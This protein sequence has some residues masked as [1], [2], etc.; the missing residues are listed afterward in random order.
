MDTRDILEQLSKRC[1]ERFESESLVLSFQEYLAE[2]L[3]RPRHHGRIA[4]RYIADCFEHFGTEVVDG[5]GGEAVRFKLFDAP[6]DDGREPLIGQE[7][8]QR[9]FYQAL[10]NFARDGRADR[11]I[12]LHGPN[13]SAKTTFCELVFRALEAYSETTEGCLHRFS[14]IFPNREAQGG[15]LGFSD[16][17][18]PRG[19]DQTY[20]FLG[21]DEIAAKIACEL[22]DPP[23]YL[24]PSDLRRELFEDLF[25]DEADRRQHAHLIEGEL[26]AK[27]K[28]IFDGLFSLYRGD[29]QQVLKHVQVERFYISQRYRSSAVRI[30]PQTHVD[31]SEVQVVADRSVHALPPAF[32]D[33]NLFVPVGD[34]VDGNRGMI[35]FSDFLKR[36]I[37]MNKYLLTTCE[38][39]I[40]MLPTSIAQLDA[41]LV[42]TSNESHLD[43][44]KTT[45][46]FASFNARMELVTVP[47]LL[48]ISKERALHERQVRSADVSIDPHVLDLAA[49]WAVLCRLHRPD[50]ENHP[51]ETRALVRELA[52]IEKAVLYDT[53]EAPER[54]AADE[55][56]LLKGAVGMLREEFRDH[57][58]FEGRYG[59]SAREM[60]QVLMDCVHDADTCLTP[61]LLFERLRRM[62]KDKTLHD[63]LRVE[64]DGGYHD[65][66]GAIDTV[67]QIY[68]ERVHAELRDAMQLVHPDE[69][70]RIFERYVQELS[71]LKKNERI[72]DPVTG[73]AREPDQGFLEDVEA[74][75]SGSDESE[76]F[77]E[78]VLGTIGAFRVEHADSEV[79]LAAL[80]PNA[81]RALQDDYFEK[82]RAAMEEVR[83]NLLLHET[84]DAEDLE[85]ELRKRVERT[86]ENLRQEHGY[87]L[88]CAKEAVAYLS[89]T[90][91]G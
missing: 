53:G 6:F 21:Q 82:N 4:A 86:M 36:P 35:E 2:F 11:L 78:A 61:S 84:D 54:L 72:Q 76:R 83:D 38:K 1:T 39:G 74:I 25:E 29:L 56:Q 13:G 41:I 87:C 67:E 15:R 48:Q 32:H 5:I 22:K 63:F 57:I 45:P 7:E 65:P 91:P 10:C 17:R 64:A 66:D 42:A 43:E 23:I 88:T 47:Y 37:E 9:E 24:L 85:P 75:V 31:A 60:R 12:L 44:L 59:P 34:L 89:R 19:R 20:A 81:L 49:T 70:V 16:E 73:K 14:W 80:F 40:V 68:R 77:R 18:R 27:S 30:A 46:L 33:V 50:P 8:I 28:R 55:R 26:S 58:H 51:P 3:E 62:T 69:Y 52:P 79:E 90:Q 71:A